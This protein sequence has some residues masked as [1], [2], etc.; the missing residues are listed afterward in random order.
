MLHEVGGVR[1]GNRVI[2]RC[3]C[4][5]EGFCCLP[6]PLRGAGFRGEGPGVPLPRLPPATYLHAFGVRDTGGVEKD[7]RQTL[8]S[9]PALWIVLIRR[10]A[11]ALRSL[12]R[13]AV[14]RAFGA[15][16]RRSSVLPE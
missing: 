5:R 15:R 14:Y 12:R 6:A 9:L 13:G 8:A 2:E 10:R 11:A 4:E 16:Y 3:R 1:K 7:N